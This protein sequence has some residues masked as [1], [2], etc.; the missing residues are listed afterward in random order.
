MEWAYTE[1]AADG[2]NHYAVVRD[3]TP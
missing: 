2:I 1:L 3:L